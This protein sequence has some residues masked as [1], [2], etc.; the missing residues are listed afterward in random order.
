MSL[1]DSVL[2][3]RLDPRA[4]GCCWLMAGG[5]SGYLVEELDLVRWSVGKRLWLLGR[6]LQTPADRPGGG[7]VGDEGEDFHISATERAQQGVD[8]IDPSDQLGPTE[9]GLA[10]EGLDGVFP[11]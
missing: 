2:P 10:G 4:R 11:C 7:E 6:Q 3:D 1:E 5:V 9:P 8:L